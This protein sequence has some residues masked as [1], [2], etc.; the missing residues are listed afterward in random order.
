MWS[1]VRAGDRLSGSGEY[2]ENNARGTRGQTRLSISRV[3]PPAELGCNEDV[4]REKEALCEQCERERRGERLRWK[5]SMK[6]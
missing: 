5:D 1:E 2:A 3:A 4:N 6:G